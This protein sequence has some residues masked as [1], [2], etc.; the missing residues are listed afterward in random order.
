MWAASLAVLV[1]GTAAS[2]QCTLQWGSQGG[3][4]GVQGVVHVAVEWDPDGAGPGGPVIVLGGNFGTAGTISATNLVSFDPATGSWAVLGGNFVGPV[5]ALVVMQNGDLVAGGRFTQAGAT[6]AAGIARWN[7]TAWTAVGGG[8]AGVPQTEVRALTVLPNGDLVAGGSF[9]GIGGVAAQN[10]A[11]WNGSAWSPLAGGVTWPGVPAPYVVAVD[12]LAVTSAGDLIAGGWFT[13]AGGT[14]AVGIARWNGVQWSALG[15]SVN[16]AVHAILPMPNGDL[17]VGG[18]FGSAGGAPAVG[19]AR[20]NGSTWSALGSGMLLP[21]G[22]GRVN[23][24]A[25]LANGDVIATGS[26]ATAGGV[27]AANIARWNGVAWS[28]LG[29]GLA[30]DPPPY[31]F[32]SGYTLCTLASGRWIVGGAF[33]EAGGRPATGVAEWSGTAWAPLTSGWSQAVHTIVR[34]GNGDLIVGGAFAA[35]GPVLANGVAIWNGAWAPLGSG[36][37]GLVRALTIA[38]TGDVIAGGDFTVAGGVPVSRVARWNGVAWSAMATGLPGTVRA[39]ATLPNGDIIAGGNRPD[40]GGA[41]VSRWNG[42]AW[43]PLG[44]LFPAGFGMSVQ[45]LAVLPNGDLVASGLFPSVAGVT[46]GNI[47]RWDGAGWSSM[48][49]GIQGAVE[50]LAVLDTGDLV[51]A[52]QFTTTA[53]I[54]APHVARWD[55]TSWHAMTT[56]NGIFGPVSASYSALL[57]LPGG[58]LLL[59]GVFQLF[60]GLAASNLVRWDGTG[61]TAMAGSD[62]RVRAMREI[63]AGVFAIGG[64]FITVGG[65]V[66]PYFAELRTPCP[67]STVATGTG[68]SGSGGTN[69]LAAAALPWLGSSCRSTATGLPANGLAL[70]IV[71]FAPAAV[72]LSA[73]LPQGGSGCTLL[74]TPD[75]VV[76]S[77]PTAGL[78]TTAVAIPSTPALAGL[79]FREQVAAIE[80]D[81]LGNIVAVTATNALVQTIG[82]L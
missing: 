62:G 51:A 52:G 10:V 67:A 12:A 68:C 64:D 32:P 82:M 40:P 28:A 18:S 77:V 30:G 31:P 19:I 73:I 71:G 5:F 6:A 59:G 42:V 29:A 47:A 48:A 7:G 11:R 26:F 38:S 16:S 15:S 58:Q 49:G 50:A 76:V 60:D 69:V 80:L 78:S 1:P 37:N 24:L 21:G 53:T 3:Q 8:L 57:P 55:G 46:V 43:S 14:S 74:T 13:T 75:L 54:L 23:G 63:A 72:P 33:A 35:A 36:T 20:W 79:T 27:A 56:G 34:R 41:F 39:L 4:V 70:A 61:W 44:G 17:I 9:A 25:R 22:L 65:L 81:P 2:A 66:S 45:A